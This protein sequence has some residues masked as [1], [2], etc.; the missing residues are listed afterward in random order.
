MDRMEVFVVPIGYLRAPFQEE[1]FALKVRER[2]T[3]RDVLEGLPLKKE[4]ILAMVVND[5]TAS[6]DTVLSHGDVLKLIPVISGG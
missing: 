2:A 5:E 6:M 4:V 3:V 1:R